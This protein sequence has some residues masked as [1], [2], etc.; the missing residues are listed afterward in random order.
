M[1][2][3]ERSTESLNFEMEFTNILET[4]AYELTDKEKVPIIRD[5]LGRESMQLIKTFTN[6]ETKMEN[7]K[8]PF[9]MSSNKF[10]PYHNRI[11]SS[12]KYFKLKRK[13]K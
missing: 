3:Q 7:C 4:K 11:V 1:N 5:W 2:A 10:K 13:T 9:S 12:L 6:E 8:G